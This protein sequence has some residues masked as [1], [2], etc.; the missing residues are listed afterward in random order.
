[1]TILNC[2]YEHNNN[3][4]LHLCSIKNRRHN[5]QKEF[6]SLKRLQNIIIIY[7]NKLIKDIKIFFFLK[8]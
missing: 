7:I 4:K 2:I 5:E 1:M 8:V 6:K 3:N